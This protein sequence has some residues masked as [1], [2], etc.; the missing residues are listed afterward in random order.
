M[1]PFDFDPI[2]DGFWGNTTSTLDWCERNY[3]V[4]TRIKI[5]DSQMLTLGQLVHSRVLQHSNKS[6]NGCT[7]WIWCLPSL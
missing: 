3:E 1:P 6:S 2:N 7:W 4:Q 5:F